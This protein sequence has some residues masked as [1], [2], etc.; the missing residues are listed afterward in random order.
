MSIR[1]TGTA[2]DSTTGPRRGPAAPLAYLV[3]RR[4]HVVGSRHN[5]FT[6]TDIRYTMR[7]QAEQQQAF[8][9]TSAVRPVNLRQSARLLCTFATRLA[10]AR[11]DQ[12][13]YDT[14]PVCIDYPSPFQNA[15]YER[16]GLQYW[17]PWKMAR[18]W[19]LTHLITTRH[20]CNDSSH[21]QA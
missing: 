3:S 17:Q 19:L 12:T 10:T 21:R 16:D 18:P 6:R 15:R 4:R 5:E 2:S 14:C 13:S 7:N 9:R 1:K 11:D 20:T 8:H